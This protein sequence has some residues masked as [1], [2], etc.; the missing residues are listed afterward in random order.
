MQRFSKKTNFKVRS[1]SLLV[2]VFS[3][4]IISANAQTQK[5]KSAGAGANGGDESPAMHEFRGVSIGMT[6]VDVRKKLGNPTDKGDEQDFYVF[7]DN[8]TAQVLYDKARTVTAFSFDYTSTAAELPTAKTIFGS[9]ADSKAD[10]SLHKL[11]R[12]P[13]AGYWL[14]YSRTAGAKPLTSI[15][16]QKIDR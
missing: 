5:G 16:F 13:K 12:Y 14:S 10:G 1:A 7:N 8:E 6:A 11:V 4:S 3:L 2:L 15:T 9:E